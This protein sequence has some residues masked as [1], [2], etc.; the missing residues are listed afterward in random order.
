M[1]RAVRLWASAVRERIT[2]PALAKA[3]IR[4]DRSGLPH[5]DAG[6]ERVLAA[7]MQWL[8]LA[9]DKSSTADG[10][11][12][13][14]YSLINGWASSYPETTGYIV[15]TFLDYAKRSGQ[16]AFRERAR[17]M[18]DWLVS[19]QMPGGGFQ[20]GKIDSTPVVPVTFNT[21]QILLGLAAAEADLGGYREPMRRAADWLVQTQDADGCWRKHPTPFAAAGEKEYETHVAWGLFEA[22]RIDP[23]RGYGRA[24]LANVQWALNSQSHN[25]WLARCCLDDPTQPLTHTLGYALRGVLEAYRFSG[26][27][28]L[29]D[30][31]RRTAEGLLSAARP[32]GYLA[33]RLRSDWSPSVS[34]VCL[35]GT[36]QVATCWLLMFQHTHEARYREAALRANAFVRR[37]VRIDGAPETLGGVKG[38]FPVD[39]E[40][41]RFEYL[42]WAAKFLADSLMLETEATALLDRNRELQPLD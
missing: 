7:L 2:L 21:G 26:D 35:T 18:A 11:V 34:W 1:K 19:I 29:L 30:A 24:G 39:G 15:N 12:A 40:Y 36:A 27:S 6:S 38:S 33:G 42:N 9:Q 14:D 16:P 31:A 13:R 25:G 17:R 8:A 37:S 32:D 10:G 41:G 5:H 23:G 28:T 20:G 22:D 3:E 4:R